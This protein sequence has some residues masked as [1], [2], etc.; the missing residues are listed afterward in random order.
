MALLSQ[1]D[2]EAKLGRSLTANEATNFALVNVANQTYVEKLIGSSVESET[3]ATRYYDGGVRF[4]KINPCT[5]VTAV[6]FVDA[7]QAVV[8]TI[9]SSDYVLDPIN[10][11]IKTQITSRY[12][13]FAS[14]FANIAVTAKF[15]I[16]D[17]SD[18]LALVKNA[19]LDA[20]ASELTDTDS[21]LKKSI[22]GYSVEYAKS[23][24]KNALDKIGLLFPEI[25]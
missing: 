9:D 2:L 7:G 15:S 24:T 21:I 8:E 22:E 3:A 20:L 13:R 12:G 4:L 14:G 16:Y 25:I 18:V 1:S 23:E 19:M 6:K 10:E 11:T 5:S 17:D